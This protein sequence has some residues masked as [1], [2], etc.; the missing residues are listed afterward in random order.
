MDHPGSGLR[1][2]LVAALAALALAACGEVEPPPEPARPVLVAQPQPAAPAAFSFAGEVRARHETPLAFRVGGK[3]LRREVENGDHVR[4]GQLLA[5]LDPQDLGLAVDAA[6]ARL[7]ASVADARLA[8]VEF[9]RMEQLFER[10]LVSRSLFDARQAALEAARSQQAQAL[11][12]LDSARLQAEHAELRA[13]AA[14]VVAQVRVEAGQV[15]APGQVLFVVAETGDREV[16]IALP[17]LDQ[18]RFAVGTA[19][20]VE[21]WVRP[22]QRLPGRL[23]EISPAADPATRTYAARVALQL[24]AGRSVEL[25]QSARVYI[26]NDAVPSLAVPLSAVTEL[27]GRPALWL[28]NPDRRSARLAPVELGPYGEREVPVLSG[29]GEN[30]W[31]VIAGVHLLREGQ[32]LAPLDRENRPLPPAPAAT[33][34]TEG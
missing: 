11:A 4:A 2:W 15:V 6:A 25:G 9:E 1:A 7:A 13:P 16:A 12:A 28:L 31:V 22:G 10:Q 27:D 29:L 8:Q 26:G 23:R 34:A 17:E 33:K 14:G 18:S 21:L 3:V 32:P 5:K 20:E 30:D 24:P 19:V